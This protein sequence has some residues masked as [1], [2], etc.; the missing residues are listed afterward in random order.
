MKLEALALDGAYRI[1]W[2]ANHDHRGAFGRL[3]CADT[4]AQ[5][6]LENLWPQTNLSRSSERGTLRGMHYQTAPCAEIKLLT[7]LA[8]RIHDVLVDLRPGSP[9]FGQWIA[10]E[11]DGAA[12]EGVYIPAGI[13][14]GFQ[15]LTPDVMLHYS[16]SHPYSPAHQAGVAFDDPDLAITWP[17]V[18]VAVSARD[19][20]LPRLRDLA[21]FH[22]NNRVP[23]GAD[24]EMSR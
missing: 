3:S 6:G 23:V 21:E 19:R 2:S 7:C 24:E 8:G 11:L 16:H 5:A 14:H 15:T 12:A 13:A 10:L 4:L 9:Q 22:E 18:P 17:L 1:G 20:T